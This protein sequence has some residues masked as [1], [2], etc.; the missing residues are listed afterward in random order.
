MTGMVSRADHRRQRWATSRPLDFRRERACGG[1]TVLRGWRTS[2]RR[3]SSPVCLYSSPLSSLR[4]YERTRI[5]RG[6]KAPAAVAPCP[7]SFAHSA[8]IPR[9]RSAV[10]FAVTPLSAEMLTI[11]YFCPHR[12]RVGLETPATRAPLVIQGTESAGVRGRGRRSHRADSGCPL[13]EPHIVAVSDS[14]GAFAL[15]TL[16]VGRA[17]AKCARD[18]LDT[19]VTRYLVIPARGGLLLTARTGAA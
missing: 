8:E 17:S 3:T 15:A 4:L 16:A 9:M 13:S 6:M 2:R 19:T 12:Q 14:G 5:A 7:Q 18:A 1:E 10:G 11:Q